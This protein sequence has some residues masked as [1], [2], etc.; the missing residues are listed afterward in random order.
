MSVARCFYS[1]LGVHNGLKILDR[2]FTQLRLK[3]SLVRSERY[4]HGPKSKLAGMRLNSMWLKLLARIF[5][6]R[7]EISLGRRCGR[8]LIQKPLNRGGLIPGKIGG[9]FKF[10]RLTLPISARSAFIGISS[11][12]IPQ[13][14]PKNHR[15]QYSS[16]FGDMIGSSDLIC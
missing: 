6:Q 1:I 16:D 11:N 3:I 9:K 2:F 5:R 10:P 8:I 12:P 7:R 4:H 13:V 15:V 14:R